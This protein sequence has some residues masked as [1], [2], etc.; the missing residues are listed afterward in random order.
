MGLQFHVGSIATTWQDAEGRHGQRDR[1]V[2]F[3]HVPRHSSV[4]R[5]PSTRCLGDAHRHVSVRVLERKC[6]SSVVKTDNAHD[7]RKRWQNWVEINTISMRSQPGVAL[8]DILKKATGTSEKIN[9]SALHRSFFPYVERIVLCGDVDHGAWQA[10]LIR[11][12]PNKLIIA[13]ITPSKPH[14]RDRITAVPGVE[15]IVERNVGPVAV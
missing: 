3:Q 4:E 12:R 10:I 1:R 8:N 2:S 9:V 6:C 14:P 13:P 5:E 11:K 15:S 7:P